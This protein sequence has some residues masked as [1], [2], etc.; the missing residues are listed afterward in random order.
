MSPDLEGIFSVSHSDPGDGPLPGTLHCVS[1]VGL[2]FN[3][4]EV[5]RTLGKL[6]FTDSLQAHALEKVRNQG[7]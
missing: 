3:A 1:V 7:P 2:T 5:D 4:V 6:F